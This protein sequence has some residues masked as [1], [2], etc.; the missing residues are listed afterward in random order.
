MEFDD[1][2]D[3]ADA[4]NQYAPVRPPDTVAGLPK[5]ASSDRAVG[6]YGSGMT[7]VIAIP[8]RDREA[9][10][11]RDQLATTSGV[12]QDRQRTVVSVGPLGVVL[13][14]AE[15]DGGWLLA[16][17]LTRAALV[18]AA[19]DV[20]DGFVYVDDGMSDRRPAV[21][22]TE[23]LTKR[24]GRIRA[25]DGI[26]L[27]VREGDVY[28]FLGAN[29]SGKTTTVRMLLGLVLADARRGR[30]CSASAMPRAG[31]RVLPRSAR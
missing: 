6:V 31:R 9:D 14:G 24:F 26:D 29:G 12:D 13:T 10:A 20:L 3:I 30:R 18:R 27:D 28:G 5:A 19:D 7:Q 8:L 22:R 17:T 25:V 1:V 4:A 21:I 23:G 15:G 16:G 2:L 11:L